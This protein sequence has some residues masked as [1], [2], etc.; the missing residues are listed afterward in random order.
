MQVCPGEKIL[1][2]ERGSLIFT[3][4]L[5]HLLDYPEE[6]NRS[7][8]MCFSIF[9]SLFLGDCLFMKINYFL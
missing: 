7:L 8:W 1:G 3:G 5:T 2:K 9:F 4:S 6:I